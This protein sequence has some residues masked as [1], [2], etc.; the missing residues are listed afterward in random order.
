M[1]SGCLQCAD[2]DFKRKSHADTV[3]VMHLWEFP[4]IEIRY[5][6]HPQAVTYLSSF[7]DVLYS[8]HEK[9]A[10]CQLTVAIQSVMISAHFMRKLWAQP[11]H[12]AGCQLLMHVFCQL[13]KLLNCHCLSL[14]ICIIMHVVSIVTMWTWLA[15]L[16]LYGSMLSLHL[17]RANVHMLL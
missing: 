12:I 17:V 6:S 1:Y 14:K 7:D 13:G 11:C 10:L 9:P 4:P 16:L 2:I 15:S 8:A 5:T 3:P